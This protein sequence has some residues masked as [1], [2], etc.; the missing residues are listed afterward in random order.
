M[1]EFQRLLITI[2]NAVMANKEIQYFKPYSYKKTIMY[3]KFLYKEG[4]ILNFLFDYQLQLFIVY[5]NRI[6]GKNLLMLIKIF[7]IKRAPKFITYKDLCT[8]NN[9]CTGAILILTHSKLG[10]ISHVD[11]L[12]NN[13]GGKLICIIR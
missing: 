5:I 10:L 2:K 4:F 8:F 1:R 7:S 12:K 6:D 13:Q 9:N 11:A 3:L